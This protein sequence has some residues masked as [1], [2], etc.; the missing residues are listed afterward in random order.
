MYTLHKGQKG[1]LTG[2]C[3]PGRYPHTMR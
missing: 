1:L 3:H 2:S